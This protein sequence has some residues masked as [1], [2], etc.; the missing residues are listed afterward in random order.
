MV[1][2]TE[3]GILII[4]GINE[5]LK[6]RKRYPRSSDENIMKNLMDFLK[7]PKLKKHQ[8]LIITGVTQALKILAEEPGI[9]DKKVMDK[10]MKEIPNI[11]NKN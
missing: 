1:D 8:I 7:D 6:Y 11:I 10:V 5:A 2:D 3:K 4:A 9:S